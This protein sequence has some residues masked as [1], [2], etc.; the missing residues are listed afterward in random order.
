VSSSRHTASS[1]GRIN[2]ITDPFLSWRDPYSSALGNLTRGSENIRVAWLWAM[3]QGQVERLA[4][5]MEGLALFYW[6]RGR[7]EEA[8]AA[9][10]P[11]TSRPGRTA[12]VRLPEAGNVLT[13]PDGHRQP[14]ARHSRKRRQLSPIRISSPLLSACCWT[15][16]PLT[17]VPLTLSRSKI[18][19]TPCCRS[20]RA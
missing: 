7:Y 10:G 13:E 14:G 12:L 5:S 1:Y 16:C 4:Q 20:M 6:L 8:K 11:S 17:K 3:E 19:K 15:R 18:T 9:P 2:P